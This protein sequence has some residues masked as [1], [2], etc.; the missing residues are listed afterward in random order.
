MAVMPTHTCV[1]PGSAT[2]PDYLEA[3]PTRLASRPAFAC[4]GLGPHRATWLKQAST[5]APGR[6]I[7]WP[8]ANYPLVRRRTHVTASPPDGYLPRSHDADHQATPVVTPAPKDEYTSAVRDPPPH[9]AELMTSARRRWSP[10]PRA[11]ELLLALAAERRHARR[12]PPSGEYCSLRRGL[13]SLSTGDSDDD[14]SAEHDLPTRADV[15]LNR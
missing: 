1:G 9:A 12:P 6:F 4:R 8:A 13:G 14:W 11:A 2:S 10:R 15:A 7:E 3:W 5:P